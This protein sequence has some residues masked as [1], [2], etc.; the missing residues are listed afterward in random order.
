M[1]NRREWQDMTD[2]QLT[3]AADRLRH[4]RS[5]FP[6]A[7]R[8]VYMDV[9][10][11]G[12][13]PQ[14]VREV[15]DRQLGE[16][17]D[18][19][20]DKA[21]RFATVER[22]R[23]HFAALVRADPDEVAYTKNV[24]E[25][26]NAVAWA[27]PWQRG[28]NV[29]LCQE[30]EHPSNVYPWLALRDRLGIEIR[31][32]RPRAHRVPV[33]EMASAI[34]ARTRVV[35]APLVTFA[36]GFRTDLDALGEACRRTGALLVVDGA[37]GIG[38]LD[39]DLSRL[40]VD[41]MAVSMQKGLLGLYGIG[42]LFVRRAVAEHLVPAYLSRY[43]VDLGDAHEAS[44]GG[45]SYALLPGA[46]RFEVGHYNFVG[47]LAA[48]P[49][50]ELLRSIGTDAIEHHVLGLAADLARRLADLGLPVLGAE[51][52]SHRAHIVAIGSAVS[53]QHEAMDDPE[54][55]S[56]FDALTEGGVLLSIRRGVLRFSLHLYNNTADIDRVVTIADEW[57]AR[58]QRAA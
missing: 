53:D 28:D 45:D 24:S 29:V 2:P 34:D 27:V 18:G 23:R 21:A 26:L 14:V 43:S 39:L 16:R 22:V 30:L 42:F 20:L 36:P 15:V 46:R 3:P 25:G 44:G 8:H 4:A 52:G 50:L 41:A 55:T 54:M 11:R 35:T 17:I 32:V 37:Q 7:T 1:A 58:R 51:P 49:A 6:G 48:E 12:L 31:A 57:L 5:L 19:R 9:A 38:V 10:A 33:A 56:L 40:P 47:A 13:L